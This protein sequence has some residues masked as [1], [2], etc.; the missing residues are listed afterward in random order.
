VEKEEKVEKGEEEGGK[1]GGLRETRRSK[2][3]R[4]LW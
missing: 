4:M 1:G 3:A 2:P